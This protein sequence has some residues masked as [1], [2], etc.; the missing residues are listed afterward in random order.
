MNKNKSFFVK[1][2][3]NIGPLVIM[4]NIA[5]GA[6][7]AFA[8]D[9]YSFLFPN[10]NQVT[11]ADNNVYPDVHLDESILPSPDSTVGDRLRAISADPSPALSMNYNS[12]SPWYDPNQLGNSQPNFG[13]KGVSFDHIAN[14][15]NIPP[16][17]EF[18]FGTGSGNFNPSEEI[19]LNANA[20]DYS[21]E[22]TVNHPHF[23]VPDANSINIPPSNGS[24]PETDSGNNGQS[25]NLQS[26]NTP[27]PSGATL[28]RLNLFVNPDSYNL[29]SG[30]G[31]C[32]YLTDL[33]KVIVKMNKNIAYRQAELGLN[34][35]QNNRDFFQ[36]LQERG[37]TPDEIRNTRLPNMTPRTRASEIYGHF[38]QNHRVWSAIFDVMFHLGY[39]R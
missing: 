19:N 25:S 6:S 5:I 32:S 30:G 36:A 38:A 21:T 24:Q 35:A 7:H 9:P 26:N 39:V 13:N 37:I 16:S 12:N 15:I 8:S 20:P 11:P 18:Q 29:S 22:S 33:Y 31:F 10:N 2:L 28:P 4:L 23:R 3:S 27:A 34:L 17:N 1:A 14:S